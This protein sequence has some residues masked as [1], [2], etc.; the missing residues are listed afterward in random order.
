V[1]FVNLIPGATYRYRGR[2]F[3]AEAGKTIEL[4]DI[5]VGGRK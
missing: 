2:D 5:T 3:T 4:P 1:T